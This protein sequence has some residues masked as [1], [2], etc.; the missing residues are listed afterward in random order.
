MLYRLVYMSRNN[1]TDDD[2][3]QEE[4][5]DILDASQRNNRQ[6]EVTGALMF[7]TGCFAQVLEGPHDKIQDTFERI[8][9]DPRH[10]HVSVLAFDRIDARLFSDWDMAFVG[11]N[12]QRIEQFARFNEKS[13]FDAAVFDGDTV[14]QLLRMHLEEAERV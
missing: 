13:G 10:S 14:Y 11:Q 7:N 5:S 8:Q 9:C 12:A 6:A 4:I 2:K 1:I 3:L